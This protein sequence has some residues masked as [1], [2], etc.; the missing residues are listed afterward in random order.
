MAVGARTWWSGLI[1]TLLFGQP[2]FEQTARAAAPIAP[3]ALTGPLADYVH[4]ED[5][6]YGWSVRREGELG[7]GRYAELT[8][9]SQKWRDVV[10]RHQL[11]L[12]KPAH[13]RDANRAILFIGG[14]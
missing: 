9:T 8:L 10:W 5:P 12:Y 11:F 14:G 2:F 1:V 7:T 6:E 13:V 3:A 4:R